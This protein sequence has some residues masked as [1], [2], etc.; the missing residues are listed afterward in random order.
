M[1][2][3]PQPSSVSLVRTAVSLVTAAIGAFGLLTLSPGHYLY[4]AS[5]ALFLLSVAMLIWVWATGI[6]ELRRRG[7]RR[8]SD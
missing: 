7:P 4:L 8:P 1:K 6:R 3:A 2:P 5:L